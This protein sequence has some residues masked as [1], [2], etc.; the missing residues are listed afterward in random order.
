MVLAVHTF[1]RQGRQGQKA[2]RQRIGVLF[3]D[4]ACA[5]FEQL[6][7]RAPECDERDGEQITRLTEQ[8][9]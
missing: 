6:G 7:E 9:P 4:I 3:L 8:K 1:E 5:V 2:T